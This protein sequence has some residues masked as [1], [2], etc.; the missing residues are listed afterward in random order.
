MLATYLAA[1]I[2]FAGIC[3]VSPVGSSYARFG[4]VS[5]GGAVFLPQVAQDTVAD[6][7]GRGRLTGL[8]LAT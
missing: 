8:V 6:F 3:G 5:A 1:S 2:V 7:H 4:A